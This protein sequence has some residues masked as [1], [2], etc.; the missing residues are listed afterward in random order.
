MIGGGPCAFIGE[1]HRMASRLDGL[2]DLSCGVFSRNQ[3]KNREAGR[4]L[5]LDSKRVY[6][7]IEAM[8]EHEL[9]LPPAERIDFV[10]IVTPNAAHFP[11]AM[12]LLISGFHVLCEKPMTVSVEEA[13]ELQKTVRK[14]RRVF[15]LMHNY[16]GYPMVKLARTICR[17]DLGKIRKVV[18]QYPQGWLA[19]PMEKKGS[20]QAAW[21]TRPGESGPSGC[22]GDIGSHC[23]NLA[24]YI[25]GLKIQEVS[26]DLSIFVKGRKLDDDGNCLLRFRGGAKGVLHASQVSIGE[27]NN[28]AIWV[29]GE[30]GGLEW[31]QET[32]ESLFVKPLDKPIQEWRRG[33]PYVGKKCAA[34]ARATRLPFGHPEG[35]IEAFANI[36][37]NFA[38]T[39]ITKKNK[40][41]PDPLALDFPDVDDGLRGMK[42]IDAVVRSSRKN[43]EWTRI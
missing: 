33:N 17:C 3:R 34:A 39:I 43:G 13:V 2:I 38:E 23:E 37:R 25:T 16:T 31:H 27:E 18:V 21:R 35:F 28:I 7:S 14:S 22:M 42:F 26:A 32:P 36:Y 4:I 9:Q 8:I 1:V 12:A 10:S 6:S 20:K 5:G 19:L 15:A 11:A 29:Y 30:K 40:T 41:K 24:E